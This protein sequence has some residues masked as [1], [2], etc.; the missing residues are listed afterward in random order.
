[1]TVDTKEVEVF[2]DQAT[3]LEKSANEL[4]ITSPEEN[5]NAMELKAKLKSTL[6]DVEAQIGRAHV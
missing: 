4:T 5:A 2:K 1:M 6:K 3:E